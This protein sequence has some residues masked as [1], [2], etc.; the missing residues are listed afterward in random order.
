MSLTSDVVL[1]WVEKIVSSECD[2]YNTNWVMHKCYNVKTML[3]SSLPPVVCRKVRVF[4]FLPY[5]DLHHFDLLDVFTFLVPVAIITQLLRYIIYIKSSWHRSCHMYI[6]SIK[7]SRW[8]QTLYKYW[9]IYKALIWY[10]SETIDNFEPKSLSNN[11]SMTTGHSTF[12]SHRL[13]ANKAKH[14][15]ENTKERSKTGWTE[16]LTK[17]K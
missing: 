17:G 3:G 15:T 10:N 8:H 13:K 6:S 5:C 12:K 1:E 7:E 4:V 16:V 14:T 9:K 11:C 2:E